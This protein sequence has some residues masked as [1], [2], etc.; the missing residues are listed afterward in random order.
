MEEVYEIL[1]YLPIDEVEVND[2]VRPLFDSASVTYE[3][4]Q[5]QF[6]YFAVHLILEEND[7]AFL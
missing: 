4:E 3:K 5:Y 6:S 1:E 2:Y 7:Y